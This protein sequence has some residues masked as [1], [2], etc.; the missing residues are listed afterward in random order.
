M[1]PTFAHGH[2]F[3]ATANRPRRRTAKFMCRASQREDAKQLLT[4]LTRVEAL[5]EEFRLEGF[6]LVSSLL[7]VPAGCLR[8][9]GGAASGLGAGCLEFGGT[10]CHFI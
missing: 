2:V 7:V 1:S 10:G 6:K 3:H 8:I 9:V 4:Q 5:V